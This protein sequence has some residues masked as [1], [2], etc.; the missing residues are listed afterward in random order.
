MSSDNTLH[1]DRLIGFLTE[2]RENV[3]FGDIIKLAEVAAQSLKGF[4]EQM[5]HTVYR[6]LNEIAGYI[7]T[8]KQEIG[9]LR[10]NDLKDSRIPSA[11]QELDAIVK[12]T[13]GATNTIME[14][15]ETLMAADASDPVAYKAL[16]D[17]HM[18]IL[19]EACSFQDITG[20]R[21]AKVV[22]TLQ[23]IEE[24]VS[25]FAE[26][27]QAKDLDG[28]MS[29]REK[30]ANARNEKLLLNGPQMAAEAIAQNDVDSLLGKPKVKAPPTAPASTG[31]AQSD[32]D[33]MFP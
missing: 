26:V 18:L 17:Q 1:F 31:S 4:F 5:D 33:A 23:H 2:K 3:T 10:A 12:A 27:M 20:Q 13:E 32:V 22:S 9:A 30:A 14:T 11:G 21:I 29:D 24:R 8:M 25:R 28:F 16:V 7:L 6:E 15:A 19:F